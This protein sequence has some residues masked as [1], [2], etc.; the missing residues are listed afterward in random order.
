MATTPVMK[1]T[2]PWTP[3]LLPEVQRIIE[4]FIL[5]RR[6]VKRVL[7][8]GSG[9]STIWFALMGVDLHS[10]EHDEDWFGEVSNVL[11]S[12]NVPQEKYDIVNGHQMDWWVSQEPI[13]KF[14]LV[15]I[16][17]VDEQRLS[18]L[19]ASLTKVKDDGWIVVDDSHWTCSRRFRM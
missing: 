10:C 17:C 8:V 12:L 7:E 4:E 1:M 14:D 18:C 9:L 19:F 13:K 3:E 11:R 6:G 5:T 16:D 2:R 15:L